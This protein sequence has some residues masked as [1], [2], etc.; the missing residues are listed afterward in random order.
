M[1]PRSS[2]PPVRLGGAPGITPFEPFRHDP[3]E[4]QGLDHVVAGARRHRSAYPRTAP[5]PAGRI[6]RV[7]DFAIETCHAWETSNLDV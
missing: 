4:L 1:E 3:V 5:P 2:R 7:D 6:G